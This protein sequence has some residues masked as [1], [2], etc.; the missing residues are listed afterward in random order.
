LQ[1]ERLSRHRNLRLSPE[2]DD[3]DIAVKV[4][5][6]VVALTG[7]VRTYAEKHLAEA[8][9]KRVVG[10]SGVANDLEV[11]VASSAVVPDP[12]IAPAAENR[13]SLSWPIAPACRIRAQY[14]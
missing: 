4:K 7:F 6:G 3:T 8:A 2:L 1:D 5:G 9:A 10:V 11:R 14:L 12:D 13:A